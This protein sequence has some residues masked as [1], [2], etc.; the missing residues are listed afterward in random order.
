MVYSPGFFPE[1]YLVE[2]VFEPWVTATIITP[3]EYVG[4]VLQ[5]LYE[6]EAEV[7]DSETFGDSRNSMTVEMPL[8]ELMR[9]FFDKLKSVSSGF[10]SISYELGEMR[11]ADV[12]KLDVLVADEVVPAFSRIVS[13]RLVEQEAEQMVEKLFG[14]LPRQMFT[15]KIQG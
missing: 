4:Q 14:V 9:G 12:V 1:D 3:I 6:H 8:R 5:I 11:Q 15:T 7:G 13:R 10:A 2:S